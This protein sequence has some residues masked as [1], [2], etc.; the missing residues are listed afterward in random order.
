MLQAASDRDVADNL[1]I[2]TLMARYCEVVDAA[3]Y[4]RRESAVAMRSIFS[5]DARADYGKGPIDGQQA[6]IDFLVDGVCA[7]RDWLWHA[8][9]TPNVDID[10]DQ[11]TGSWTIVAMMKEKGQ[12]RIGS[13]VGRYVNAFVRTDDRW[14]ISSMRW[15]AEATLP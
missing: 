11:A 9:H 10:G 14:R 6:V 3:V 15:I 13:V 1:A 4:N 5:A 7:T 8:I 12:S 2:Q